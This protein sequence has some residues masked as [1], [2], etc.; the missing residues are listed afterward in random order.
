MDL[1]MKVTCKVLQ[2]RVHSDVNGN[3]T[4]C[5]SFFRVS[6]TWH[7]MPILM[8][9]WSLNV[10]QK[11]LLIAGFVLRVGPFLPIPIFFPYTIEFGIPNISL[12]ILFQF[13][14]TNY[15]IFLLEIWWQLRYEHHQNGKGIRWVRARRLL[16]SR[17]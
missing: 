9:F 13:E 15:V 1:E 8:P 5:F 6:Y 14:V 3:K 17:T 10:E 7:M 2:E 12:Q 11:Q 16:W 4:F